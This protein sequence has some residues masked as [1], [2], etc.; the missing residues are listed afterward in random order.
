MRQSIAQV[1]PFL[2]LA[3]PR[4]HVV[5]GAVYRD[6]TTG[7]E[8][9]LRLIGS[10]VRLEATSK[11]A[12]HRGDALQPVTFRELRTTMIVPLG[13]WIELGMALGTNDAVTRAILASG[14]D[15]AQQRY[16]AR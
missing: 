11:L 10:Q 6:V 9:V 12:F 13:P 2:I 8:V 1:Q 14:V 15:H 5:A 16:S 3:E 4:L 7:F